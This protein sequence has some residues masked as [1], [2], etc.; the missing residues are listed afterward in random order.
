MTINLEATSLSAIRPSGET[1]ER[2]MPGTLSVVGYGRVRGV[3]LP[4]FCWMGGLEK[5]SAT[6]GSGQTGESGGIHA[7]TKKILN[8]FRIVG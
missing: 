4:E 1:L 5:R 7:K 3:W 2:V 6:N 8:V